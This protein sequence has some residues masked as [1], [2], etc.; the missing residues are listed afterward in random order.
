MSFLENIYNTILNILREVYQ[1]I[2]EEIQYY[3][4]NRIYCKKTYM[5]K[6]K[7]F[8]LKRATFLLSSVRNVAKKQQYRLTF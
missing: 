5:Y 2:I 1:D 3:F 6:H 7:N 4:E 8:D